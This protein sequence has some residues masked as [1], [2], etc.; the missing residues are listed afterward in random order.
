[1][2]EFRLTPD[3]NTDR[4]HQLETAM[5]PPRRL[6]AVFGRPGDG[7]EYKVSGEYVFT[8]P[9][10]EVFTV[11]DWKA[12]SLFDDYVSEGEENELPTPED[13]WG[14][15][16]PEE[17]HIGGRSARRVAAFKKWLLARVAE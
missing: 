17:F 8:G 11:Y 10:G 15:W 1:M 16:N 2:D 5:I 14:N 9:K 7:D 12:T 4:T 13:F 3:A 6:V